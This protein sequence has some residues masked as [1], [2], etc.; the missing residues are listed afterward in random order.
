MFPQNHSKVHTC[1]TKCLSAIGIEFSH[2]LALM[3][4]QYW[5]FL[6]VKHFSHNSLIL[7]D[8]LKVI[9]IYYYCFMQYY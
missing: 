2:I 1:L 3:Y 8:L 6:N 4:I 9:L 5:S 7:R